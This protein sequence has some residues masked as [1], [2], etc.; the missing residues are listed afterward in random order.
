MIWK[1]TMIW[2]AAGVILALIGGFIFWWMRRRRQPR[3]ISFV[4]LLGTLRVLN[5]DR[6]WRYTQPKRRPPLR[7]AFA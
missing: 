1:E 5:D 4:A 2:I 6:I 3:L 7:E